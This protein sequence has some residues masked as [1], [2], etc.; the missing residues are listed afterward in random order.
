MGVFGV[1]FFT[2][3]AEVGFARFEAA[4]S[5]RVGDDAGEELVS[6]FDLRMIGSEVLTQKTLM[7]RDDR[8]ANLLVRHI[9]AR[10]D[11]R[12]DG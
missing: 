12:F 5:V 3:A 11:S 2:A 4:L 6:A 7:K 1:E 10:D 8:V 9:V